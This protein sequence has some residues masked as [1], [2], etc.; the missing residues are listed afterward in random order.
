MN[1]RDVACTQY[2]DCLCSPEMEIRVVEVDELG[3][4]TTHL[5]YGGEQSDDTFSI[6]V[7]T[8]KHFSKGEY[9][10]NKSSKEIIIILYLI[11]CK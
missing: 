5:V 1:L 6:P 7:E 9:V 10:I 11:Y 8:L 2:M 3:G 4:E